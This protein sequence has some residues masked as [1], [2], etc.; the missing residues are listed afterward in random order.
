M[1][2][3]DNVPSY[4][5]IDNWVRKCGLDELKHAPEALKGID[6]AALMDECMMIGS[7]K[8]LPVLSIPADH[9]GR[10]VQ[11]D[12]VKVLGF[13]VSSSW[14][15]DTVA[16]TFKDNIEEVGTSPKYVITDNDSKMRKA[17]KLAGYTWHRDISHTLAMFME[18]TYKDDAEFVD[19]NKSMATC[20]K[21]FCMKEIAYLQS[22]SQR[23]KARF[24]NLSDSI[25]W[26]D[27]IL[28]LFHK[29][30]PYEREAFSFIQQY[31]SLIEELKEMV[32]CIHYVETEMKHHGLS[33]KTI[34]TCRKYVSATAMRGNDR[35]RMVGQQILDYFVEEE[36][37]LG[38]NEVVNNS[39]DIIESIFGIFKYKQSPN[40]LNGVTTLVLHL[41]V[42]LAFSGNSASENYNVK[43]RL[44]RTKVKDIT[45]WRDENLLENLVSK[46][47]K[48]L[49][50]A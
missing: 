42:I 6:Y 46:R 36:S 4:N 17:V 24:M 45:S 15:A 13:N 31:A 18:R 16:E 20:K 49:G 34:A 2:L 27:T 41:P 25:D 1:G 48:R 30:S 47:N 28:Q 43:E 38:D 14:N 37:Q 33:K 32:S 26:A 5:T 23:T 3:I 35:M 22:P 39:S 12:D 9:Q 10:P 19:F 7:E 44:C 11:M 8:L 50:A 21:Q 40:K 29:L